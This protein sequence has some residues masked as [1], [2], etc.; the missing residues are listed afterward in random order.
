MYL[1]ARTMHSTERRLWGLSG[2]RERR[3][4]TRNG[5][6]LYYILQQIQA[7]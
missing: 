2:A 1:V 7:I 3:S 4:L 5:M 6:G